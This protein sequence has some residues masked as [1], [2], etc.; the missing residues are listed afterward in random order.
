M[1]MLFKNTRIP[2]MS[3]P[4]GQQQ[5]E[6]LNTESFQIFHNLN[7][8]GLEAMNRNGRRPKKANHGRRPVCRAGR[9]AKNRKWGNPR[10]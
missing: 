7:S 5:G 6:A 8:N 4:K 1:M 10:R 3:L 2:S 9:R